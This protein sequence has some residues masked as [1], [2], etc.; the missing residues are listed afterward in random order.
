LK[1]HEAENRKFWRGIAAAVL[2][3]AI[4]GSLGW[5]IYTLLAVRGAH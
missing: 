2:T 3:W 5:A 1:E 4:I